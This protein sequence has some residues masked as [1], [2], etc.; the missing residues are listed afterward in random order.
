MKQYKFLSKIFFCLTFF[1]VFGVFGQQKQSVIIFSKT[2]GYRHNSIEDGIKS[3]EKLGREN[4]F[5]VFATEDSKILIE[6]LKN[7][8]AVIFLNTTGDILNE[9]E[10]KVFIK[11]INNGGGFVGIHAA[12]DT[13]YGWPWYGKMVGAYFLSHPKQQD[14]VINVVNRDH[15]STSFLGNQWNKFDEWYNYKDINTSI[16]VLLNLD[17]NSYEGGKNGKNHPIAWYHEFEGGKIFYTGTGHTKE[18]Y[19]NEKFLKHILGGIMYV[20]N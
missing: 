8:D 17:E 14:A 15:L 11:Y 9:Q 1:M 12:A 13:E 16:Q 5:N 6:E 7:N 19:L 20:I 3:I 2:E 10:Q 18:S 4:N